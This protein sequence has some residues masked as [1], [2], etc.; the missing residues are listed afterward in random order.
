MPPAIHVLNGP[1]LNLLGEREPHIYGR[2]TLAD[3][4]AACRSV[5]DLHGLSLVFRQTNAEHEL[6]DWLHATRK[7]AAVGVAINP[8][9][10]CY[11]S[12]AV[13]DALKACDCPVIEV[14]LSNIH[15]RDEA[16]RA[17]TL[18]ATAVTGLISGLG[19]GGYV[20][21]VE[22]LAQKYKATSAA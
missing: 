17:D 13:L 4:E 9:A 15:R 20:L 5:T 7:G 11:H 16:W 1:N 2:D 10:F 8:A 14:H 6:I 22:W 12:V 3:A 18:T 19:I 21:A